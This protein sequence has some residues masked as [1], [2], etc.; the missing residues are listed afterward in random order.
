MRLDA[1]PAAVAPYLRADWHEEDAV[2]SP[3]GRWLLYVS[4]QGD[5]HAAFVRSFPEPGPE[6]RISGGAGSDPV[7]A[8]DGRAVYYRGLNNF[9]R[10]N[11]RLGETVELGEETTLFSLA[12]T[13]WNTR[14]RMLD[15]HPDGDRF[16]FVTAGEAV[17][18]ELTSPTYEGIGPF[19]VV[20]NW[21][22]ELC[23]RM[24]GC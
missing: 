23:E 6:V 22:E 24:G 5:E 12:G 13:T 7:W 15:I 9:M 20:V 2:V 11:V 19:V 3:D 21:F 16:L 18:A 17:E 10:R 4:S 1:D 14:M 8:P